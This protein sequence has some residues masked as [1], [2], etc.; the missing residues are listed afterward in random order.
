MPTHPDPSPARASA[1]PMIFADD[2]V[3]RLHL[4]WRVEP[5]LQDPGNPL[6]EPEFPWESACPACGHGTVL[7]D[8]IDGLFK[9]WVVCVED[10]PDPE[11]WFPGGAIFRLAYYT[12]QDGVRWERP[13]LDLCPQPGYPLN[14]LIFDYPSG[15]RSSYA[16]V[17][18]EPEINPAEPYEMF[19]FRSPTKGPPGGPP[20]PGYIVAGFGQKPL[21]SPEQAF[22][23]C[24]GWALY[25]YRSRDGIHWRGVEGPLDLRSG[26]TLYIHRAREGGY[27]A[28]YKITQP[29]FPGGMVRYDCGAGT[30]RIVCRQAS[31]DGS[32][33]NPGAP[34]LM[35]DIL[36]HQNDQIM[37]VGY[38]PCGA[39]IIG[40]TAVYH[41]ATQTMDLQFAASRDGLK[42]WRPA[43]ASC[44]PLAPLGDYGG[45]MIWPTRTLVPAEGRLYLYYGALRGLHGDVYS[46]TPSAYQFHGAF[47][48]CSWEEGR[49][50]AAVPAS[51]GSRQEA[52]LTTPLQPCLGAA[53]T[54]NA[55]TGR[56]GC[57]RAELLGPDRK[58]LPGFGRDDFEPFVGNETHARRG[59]RGG[60]PPPE[61]HLR[62]MLREA[63]LY[64]YELT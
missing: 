53:L 44:L 35:P 9:A 56:N 32:H 33:W 8:P 13:L 26:D 60:M 58:V 23:P 51:G 47:S 28:H 62:L 19:V 57:V 1:P 54:L 20:P 48:R 10:R 2:F 43:R 17:L 18:I 7:R 40:L 45:G 59:W 37:E 6:L 36:D 24:F 38:Y 15:G 39:G 21:A 11:K 3:E 5:G 63:R 34:I 30:C 49:L 29:A 16:S 52:V 25:R 61:A 46:R 55:A 41:A 12:S 31:D 14:N 22:T 4:A 27:V 42:W 50:W 64:G